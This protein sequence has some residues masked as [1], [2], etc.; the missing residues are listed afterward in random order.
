M[1]YHICTLAHDGLF[2]LRATLEALNIEVPS[3]KMKIDMAFL[4]ELKGLEFGVSTENEI[5]KKKEKS[6][7][8]DVFSLEGESA[9]PGESSESSE[10]SSTEESQAETGENENPE[11]GEDEAWSEE[12]AQKHWDELEP[13][14]KTK[15]ANE[16][17]LEG[18]WGRKPW[19]DLKDEEKAK[20]Y[21]L[22]ESEPEEPGEPTLEEMDLKQLLAFA[23]DKKIKLTE[24]QTVSADKARKAIEV[25]LDE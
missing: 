17:G 9:D 7:V 23:L 24:K 15:Q 14:A 21:T 4:N 6:R 16:A 20:M 22:A 8:V 2:N 13:K 11:S 19:A 1:L 12:E 18:K 3:S 25:A 5:Y 10:T